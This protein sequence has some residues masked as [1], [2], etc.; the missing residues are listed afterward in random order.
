MGKAKLI[1]LFF[2]SI[3]IIVVFSLFLWPS[4]WIEYVW[5]CEP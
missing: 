4:L 3:S 2:I 5:E 1:L